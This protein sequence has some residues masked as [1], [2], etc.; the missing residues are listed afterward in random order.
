MVE[1]IFGELYDNHFVPKLARLV[2]YVIVLSNMEK[3]FFELRGVKHVSV[4][5]GGVSLPRVKPSRAISEQLLKKWK[6][7]ETSDEFLIL[8]VGRI[9]WYKGFQYI[10]KALPKLAEKKIRAKAVIVGKDQGFREILEKLARNLDVEE[11]VVFTGEI[12]NEELE[13]LY[14][15]SDIV[16]VPS[17]FEAYGRVVVE[18]WAHKKP[19]VASKFIGGA[20]LVAKVGGIS[21]DPRDP[22]ELAD[23]ITTLL[24]D[25]KLAA[26]LAGRGYSLVKK[27]LTYGKTVDKIEKVYQD[28]KKLVFQQEPRDI[29]C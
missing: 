10:I 21:V 6:L 14:Q 13:V 1:R 24:L 19:V 28:S 16:V 11:N 12:S 22:K 20:E 2:D 15:M 5:H 25:E 23:A 3:K 17:L 9:K 26:K 8:A 29:N 7:K 4:I 18:A 27:E